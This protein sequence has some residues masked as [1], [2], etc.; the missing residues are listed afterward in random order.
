MPSKKIIT[1][2]QRYASTT[3]HMP[4]NPNRDTC[5][6]GLLAAADII[7]RIPERAVDFLNVEIERREL[8]LL[9]VD[10]QHRRLSWHPWSMIKLLAIAGFAAFSVSW[11][12]GM[13]LDF[14]KLY[15]QTVNKT[16]GAPMGAFGISIPSISGLLP[17][18]LAGAFTTLPRI[19]VSESVMIA[20]GAIAVIALIKGAIIL[21]NWKKIKLVG[22]AKKRIEGELETLKQWAAHTEAP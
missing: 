19:G 6:P 4:M 15:E 10:E 11:G 22:T 20:G 16:A 7:G 18:P 5:P 13:M 9:R 17:Q 8:D 3:P 21:A 14:L 1:H 2:L 12:G